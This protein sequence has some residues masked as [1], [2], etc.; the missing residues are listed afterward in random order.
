MPSKNK[1]T[2]L[3]ET[4]NCD[5]II[6]GLIFIFDPRES[7]SVERERSGNSRTPHRQTDVGMLQRRGARLSLR[8]SPVAQHTDSN[9]PGSKILPRTGPVVW[10]LRTHEHTRRSTAR[11]RVHVR[12]KVNGCVK[13]WSDGSRVDLAVENS[14]TLLSPRV[15]T[16]SPSSPPRISSKNSRVQVMTCQRVLYVR[17]EHLSVMLFTACVCVVQCWS[18]DGLQLLLEVNGFTVSWRMDEF[19]PPLKSFIGYIRCSW[20]TRLVWFLC[21]VK[22]RF[23]ISYFIFLYFNPSLRINGINQKT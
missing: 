12:P 22:E 14:T 19:F 17:A 3:D 13:S 16:P 20:R 8:N 10:Q 21:E 18:A 5:N 7:F 6:R 15:Y 9:L 1:M 11:S 23:C 2:F 4:W